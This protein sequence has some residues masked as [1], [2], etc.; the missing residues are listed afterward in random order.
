M[1]TVLDAPLAAPLETDDEDH[2]PSTGESVV[3]HGIT[4]KMYRRLRRMPEN[5]N[6][7]MTYDRGELEI[8][9]PSRVHEEIALLLG[10]LI[11][12]WTLELGIEI[13]AC[14]TMTIRRRDLD[15][16]FEPDNCYYVQHE[17]EMRS[18]K[19][20]DFKVDPPPDLAIEV[21]VTRKLG[22][23]AEIYATFGVPELWVWSAGALKVFELSKDGKY[24]PRN[25]SVCFPNLPIAKFE[26]VVRQLGTMGRTTL[27]RSFRDW[28]RANLPSNI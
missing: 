20:V 14:R 21:E 10:T 11:E 1:A 28:V 16:G 4:W 18:K 6:I 23:K 9:S 15:R 19:E 7:R 17:L 27:L 24:A 22:A 12:I 26:E 13:V 5:S 2:V 25:T 3:L 8:M